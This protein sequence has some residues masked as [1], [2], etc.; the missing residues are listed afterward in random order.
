[1]K[2]NNLPRDIYEKYKKDGFTD[3]EIEQI[4]IDRETMIN[5]Y[6]DR[7]PREITSSTYLRSE[8]KLRKKVE[9]FMRRA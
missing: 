5:L 7:K 9:D 6:R 8:K 2:S 3:D 1:M 4:C